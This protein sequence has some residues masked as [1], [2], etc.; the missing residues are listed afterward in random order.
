M[1]NSNVFFCIK[2]A[3]LSG[4]FGGLTGCDQLKVTPV[5]VSGQPIVG[6]WYGEMTSGDENNA[7]SQRLYLHIRQDGLARYASLLCRQNRQSGDLSPR[8]LALP[9]L[10]IKRLSEKKLVVQQYPLSTQFEFSLGVWPDEKNQEFEVDTLLL[11]PISD[12]SV[13]DIDSW[14]CTP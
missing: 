14:R 10:P 3:L 4:L 13:P 8:L 12:D 7:F 1:L 9:Y 5:D 2:V 6:H 11:K